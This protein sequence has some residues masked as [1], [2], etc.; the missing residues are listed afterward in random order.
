MDKNKTTFDKIIRLLT[1][2]KF[3]MI[4]LLFIA[5]LSIIGTVIPQEYSLAF[6]EAN[7]SGII[8]EVILTFSLYKVYSSWWFIALVVA[9]CINLVFCSIRRIKTI[10]HRIFKEPDLDK[11]FS[12]IT[13]F[14]EIDIDKSNIETIFEKL[15]F[16]NISEKPII[17]SCQEGKLYYSDKNRIGHLGSWLTHIGI[18]IIVIFFTYGKLK[19]FDVYVYGVP[20]QELEVENTDIS[21]YIEDFNIE[22]REDYSVEQ[23]ISDLVI[24]K[25]GQVEEDGQI[26]VNNPMRINDLNIYQNSTGWALN[27]Y[28]YKEGEEYSNKLMYEGDLFIEDDQKI[29][30]QFTS[31]YPDFD[32]S[33][34]TL[35]S[36]T[37]LLN[38]PLALYAL[39]YDGYR[40][41]MNLVHMNTPVE[42]EEYSF[43]FNEPQRYTLLQVGHDPG[44]TGAFIG[45]LILTLGVFLAMFI[46]PRKLYVYLNSEGNVSIYSKSHKNQV[47]YQEEVSRALEDIKKESEDKTKEGGT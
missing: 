11:E 1:S 28:L 12:S 6:Y 22:F 40:V 35:R 39:F 17:S 37:P 3:G 45:G 29:V 9:L 14:K 16:K 10:L 33:S 21:I 19:G 26:S 24:L 23:Y 4:L 34:D 31:F 32:A 41:D 7:Y 18:I 30:I 20:G 27:A 43:V 2:M 38:H 46:N 42:Y 13:D 5:I 47:V 25:D 8:L 15:R 44:K 36:K